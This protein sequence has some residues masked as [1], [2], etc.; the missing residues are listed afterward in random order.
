MLSGCMRWLVLH[1]SCLW[2][3]DA[4]TA[5]LN[6]LLADAW[7]VLAGRWQHAL[8][9]Q[10]VRIGM[11]SPGLQ[12]AGT[13]SSIQVNCVR[14]ALHH[15]G[16]LTAESTTC[17]LCCGLVVESLGVL[18]VQSL[19]ARPRHLVVTLQAPR[20]GAGLL[21]DRVTSHSIERLRRAACLFVATAS[22]EACAGTAPRLCEESPIEKERAAWFTRVK[23][24][25]A[26]A[27]L[28][29]SGLQGSAVGS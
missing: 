3:A 2:D 21:I 13:G 16:R 26:P 22:A 20:V 7:R 28:V 15:A 4:F 9:L 24:C 27:A 6:S 11:E 8:A 10:Q 18:L 1:T 12:G 17:G 14:A 19:P 29:V 23:G 5:G 25:V